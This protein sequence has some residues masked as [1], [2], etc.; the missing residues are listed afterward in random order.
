[1]KTWLRVVTIIE[2]AKVLID[3]SNKDP[4]TEAPTYDILRGITNKSYIIRLDKALPAEPVVTNITA[5]SGEAP[6]CRPIVTENALIKSLLGKALIY[7][8]V[9]AT[10]ELMNSSPAITKLSVIGDA[11]LATSPVTTLNKILEISIG[12]ALYNIRV[13]A[14]K[15]KAIKSKKRVYFS[16]VVKP[17]DTDR[18]LYKVVSAT[19]Y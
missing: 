18:Y 3:R 8:D 12:G 6:P 13:I 7:L 17:I 2:A 11:L 16:S 1:S 19:N 9:I 14:T 5:T 15:A 4:A 10:P